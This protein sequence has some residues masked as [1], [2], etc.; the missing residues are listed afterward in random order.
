LRAFEAASVPCGPV[1]TI[2]EA[3]RDPRLAAGGMCTE[4]RHA[5]AGPFRLVN[6]PFLFSR[7]AAGIGPAPEVGQDETKILTNS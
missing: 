6:T 4:L 1:H 7:S 5:G 2:A 3:A